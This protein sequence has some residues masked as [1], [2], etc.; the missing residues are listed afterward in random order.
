MSRPWSLRGRLLRRVLLGI[1]LSWGLGLSLAVGA[2]NHEMGELVDESLKATAKVVLSLY[3][4]AGAVRLPQQPADIA[5]RITRQ[6]QEIDN[7]AWPPLGQDGG[8]D[9][10][11]WRVV[12]LSNPDE[13]ISV[14]VGQSNDWRREELTESV[15]WLIAIMLPVLVVALF[16]VSRA[17][18]SALRPADRFALNL[19]ARKPGDLTPIDAPRLPREL[20]PIRD[21][22]N[23]Y[24]HRI[25]THVEA[26]RQFAVH[27]AHELRTP[28]A[29]ASAQAQAIA[30][31][32]ADPDAAHRIVEALRRLGELVDRLL[33]LSRAEAADTGLATCDLVQITRLVMADLRGDVTFDDGDVES[34]IVPIHP[35]ALALILGNLLRN[36]RDHGTGRVRVT[37]HE[38]PILTISNP[39]RAD[40]AFQHRAFEKS[41]E[42]GGSGLGLSI[43]HKIAS[44]EGVALDFALNNGFAQVILRFDASPDPEKHQLA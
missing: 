41:T 12:R 18:A 43:V 19:Q 30:A 16:A 17:V 20:A 25:R 22:M 23:F 31:S 14:E 13:G 42:S 24:L 39:A 33:Q 29:A 6:G 21:S 10:P 36:A 5:F 34:A 2:L 38:G 4:E 8:H 3:R 15:A 28:V 27:A 32:V 40:A 1:S 11:G 37:L 7:A 26:E 9:V 44:K 35:E